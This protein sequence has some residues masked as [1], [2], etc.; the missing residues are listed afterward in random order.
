VSR[1]LRITHSTLFSY[2]SPVAETVMELRLQPQATAAQRLLDFVLEVQPTGPLSSYVDGFG[3]TVHHLERIQAQTSLEVVAHIHVECNGEPEPA[4]GG[5]PPLD[6]LRFRGPVTKIPGIR[7][8]AAPVRQGLGSTAPAQEAAVGELTAVI[9]ARLRYEK[10]ATTV[11]SGVAEVLALGAGVCQDFA[12]VLIA[13]CRLLGIPARYVSGYV[14]EGEDATHESHAWVEAWF[15]GMGWRGFD[16]THPVRVGDRHV[17][18]A[19]GRD[20]T[21]CAPTRGVY[22]GSGGNSTMEAHVTVSAD[23]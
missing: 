20:Y 23:A 4:G 12:H 13:C 15:P 21:D 11:H 10:G 5:P 2:E 1:R 17:K 14:Y 16:P 19:V 7:R 8:L 18:V 6:M 3:N 22:V 9:A